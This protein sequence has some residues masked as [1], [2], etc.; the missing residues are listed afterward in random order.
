MIGF[1]EGEGVSDTRPIPQGQAT[2][3]ES[4][5]RI[6][7][8]LPCLNEARTIAGVVHGFSMQLPGADIFV[9][10]NGST[11]GT[12]AIARAAG[13]HVLVESAQG[14]GNAIRRAFTAINADV[15]VIADGDG[16][17]DASQAP[18]LIQLLRQ[19]CL[20]M[21]V[22][23]R[24][25]ISPAA[26]RR[27]HE[28]GNRLFNRTLKALFRSSF[29]DLFSGYRVL[30]DRYVKSFPALCSGFEVETEMTVH[31]ILLRMPAAEVDCDYDARPP[32]ST[33]KL[34]KYRDGLRILRAM[35]NFLR[36]HRPLAF[37]SIA[38]ALT[39]AAGGALFSPVLAEYLRTGLV[40]RI[41]TLIVAVGFA[42][43]SV[44][45]MTCGLILDTTTRTQLELRRLIYL[46]T[47][48]DP[49]GRRG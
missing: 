47:R 22:A 17:Y 12:A 30:S 43:I 49:S 27:G 48:R 23:A 8:I 33:S 25:K 46:N 5:P 9:I 20:D 32:G 19:D 28:V 11:D 39:L 14:K 37:F 31:A 35:L 41:P 24:R 34:K 36:Q 4:N 6:A 29:R 3:G 15:Y 26:F 7:V 42:V 21:V 18:Y 38:S 2:R 10:D 40:P 45:L 44:L 13:A 1:S 16:T